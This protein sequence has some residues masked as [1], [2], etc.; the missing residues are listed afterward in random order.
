MFVNGFEIRLDVIE[1]LEDEGFVVAQSSL[2]SG[3]GIEGC[4]R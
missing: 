2:L 3:E 4:V 1:N